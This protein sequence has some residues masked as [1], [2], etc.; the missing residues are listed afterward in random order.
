MHPDESWPNITIKGCSVVIDGNS[1]PFYLAKKIDLSLEFGGD[2]PALRNCMESFFDALT[3]NNVHPIHIVFNG[4]NPH[5]KLETVRRRY[6]A[7]Q[8]DHYTGKDSKL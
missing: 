3:S 2:Y 4:M 8:R 5:D 1:L 7:R 6:E